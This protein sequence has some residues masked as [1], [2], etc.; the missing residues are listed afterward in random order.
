MDIGVTWPKKNDHVFKVLEWFIELRL[1]FKSVKCLLCVI[2]A[3][4]IDTY[5]EFEV[6]GLWTVM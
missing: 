3:H 5:L 1:N 2:C 6:Y 4:A